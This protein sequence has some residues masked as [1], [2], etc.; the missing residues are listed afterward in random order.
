M[1]EVLPV[2]VPTGYVAAR[3]DLGERRPLAGCTT[4]VRL[5][6]RRKGAVA[7]IKPCETLFPSIQPPTITPA[8]LVPLR[9]VPSD[10]WG[11]FKRVKRPSL[12]R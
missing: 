5:V 8:A 7:A 4:R 12:R 10:P 1:I 11:S 2:D 9:N 6:V 3:V